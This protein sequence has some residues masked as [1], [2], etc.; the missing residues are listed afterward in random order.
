MP[1][2]GA[3]IGPI[4]EQRVEGGQGAVEEM[5]EIEVKPV[6]PRGE[7]SRC[8]MHPGERLALS[9]HIARD[10]FRVSARDEVEQEGETG[11]LRVRRRL[12]VT[13]A[14]ADEHRD[15]RHLLAAQMG[16]QPRL[17][18]QIGATPPAVT[19]QAQDQSPI[20]GSNG[21]KIIETPP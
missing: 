8:G 19:G 1:A 2:I 13:S 14:P 16:E 7:T 10:L 12:R 9:V 11:P 21:V 20:A 15:N 17:V 5:I 6:V 18:F 3:I 4:V